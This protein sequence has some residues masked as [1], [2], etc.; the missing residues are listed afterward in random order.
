MQP[1]GGFW[2]RF[3]AYIIDAIILQIVA[4]VLGLFVGVGIGAAGAGEDAVAASTLIAVGLS[5]VI[6]WL[7]Y[8]ILESSEWQGT[9]G[10]KALSLVVTDESGERLGFGRA[11]GRYF[12]KFLSSFILAF[13]FF[14]IGWTQRKQGLHDMIA[15]TLVHK[16]N[17]PDLIRSS[18]AVFE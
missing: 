8:A 14:M 3:V 7:Y 9:V 18:A 11:T 4:T 10:K 12:A 6:N 1:Y 13:G 2:I 5:L 17:S 15:G 16:T